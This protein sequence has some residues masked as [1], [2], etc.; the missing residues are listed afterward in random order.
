MKR[1][2]SLLVALGGVLALGPNLVRAQAFDAI[3]IER[4]DGEVQIQ[5]RF[6]ARVLYRRHVVAPA[7]NAI[8]IYI[9]EAVRSEALQ[10][11][12]EDT[13]RSPPSD[14]VPPFTV[15]YRAERAVS[16]RRVVVT[17]ARPVRVSARQGAEADTIELLVAA[18]A[19]APPPAPAPVA[20]PPAIPPTAAP[21][22]AAPPSP[23]A[24]AAEVEAQA[25]QLLAQAKAAL[26]QNRA[27]EA[28]D[29]LNRLLNL[30][31]SA[32]SREAQELVGNVRE[33]LGQE[34]RARA[35]Y[36]L[37]LRLYPDGADAERV[38]QRLAAL[39]AAPAPGA[40]PSRRPRPA[41]ASVW[42]SV[43]QYYYG[44]Q[45]QVD[46]T[47]TVIT[48]ATNATVIDTQRLTATD[49]SSLATLVDLNARYRGEDWDNRFVFRDTYMASFLQQQRSRNRLYSLYGD[50]KNIRLGT[51][52]RIGRQTSTGGGVLGRYD[53]GSLSYSP[54]GRWRIGVLGGTPSEDTPGGR[55]TFFGQSL[56][57]ENI[58]D[59]LGL[60][61]FNITQRVGGFTDRH[62]VG[63]ELRYFDQ[64]RSL[65]GYLDYDRTFSALNIGSLQ[66]S[67]TF[68]AGP[69]FNLLY[70]YR[71]APTLQL[72]NLL[73]GEPSATLRGALQARPLDEA[74]AAVNAST[75]I[76]RVFLVGTTLPVL[77]RWQLGLEYRAS[78]L[79]GAAAS[80]N[81][82]A[83][84]A[85]GRIDTYTLQAIGTSIWG[86]YDVVALT[87]SYL[88]GEKSTAWLAA[89]NPR[90]QFF[91]RLRVEPSLRWYRQDDTATGVETV[92]VTPGLRLTYSLTDRFALESEATVERSRADGPSISETVQ[93]VFYFIGFRWD[94][95]GRPA[96]AA[97]RPPIQSLAQPK[98]PADPVN[99]LG[100]PRGGN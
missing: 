71:R 96:P 83:T 93:R 68:A 90:L 1:T 89:L 13:R 86:R 91:D 20:P 56:D 7:G 54:S 26:A 30:P 28:L 12:L 47:T 23:A 2:L 24:P 48:P 70:D 65:F 100:L 42:G 52:A 95:E 55:Q 94:F 92:R 15:S 74:R 69:S 44:G 49:Q 79:S 10:G 61:L 51:Q 72:S 9:E 4:R 87:G 76:S 21:P 84:P 53:G 8:E 14:L 25:Q 98:P 38:R 99:T 18:P 33:S 5:I 6:N 27:D 82:P 80:G 59:G 34:A 88:R 11:V 77:T 31:P 16:L 67:W 29:T 57:F 78:E 75:P 19:G 97:E 41:V 60:G 81:L 63:G 43:S 35:E 17:F 64:H 45:S 73:I 36:R 62:A 50:V 40:P 3:E 22:T 39:E 37:F 58:V 85:T 46:T 32:A 66:G